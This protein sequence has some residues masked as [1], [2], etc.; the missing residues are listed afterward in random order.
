MKQ[1]AKLIH[2]IFLVGEVI[3]G[4]L[5]VMAIVFLLNFMTGIM[6]PQVVPTGWKIIRPPDEVSALI[7]DNDTVWTGG[8]NGLILINRNQSS[9]IPKPAGT[10]QF[11]FVHALLKDHTDA[12]W[13][14]HDGG[15]A[16]YRNG[17]WNTVSGAPFRRA[18]SLLED[19][20]GRI[21]VGSDAMVAYYDGKSW[22]T[23]SP[24]DGM[25]LASIDVLYEDHNGTIWM[26]CSAP[27]NAGLYKL[28]GTS[29]RYYSVEDGLPHQ[30]VRAIS[31]SRN[32]TIWIATGFS[33]NGGL[34]EVKDGNWT[35]STTHEGLA[36]N[37]TRS[38]YEDRSG[39]IWVGSEYDGMVVFDHGKRH[40]LTTKEG[41]AGNEVKVM[42]EDDNGVF[43]LGTSGGLTRIESSF[44]FANCSCPERI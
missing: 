29:W 31:Q 26:G 12:M 11:G 6:N 28:N 37:V 22:M 24:A 14:A 43:W 44:L 7:I 20:Q 5:F 33:N 25:R 16:C 34:V 18:L 41:L 1:Q 40:I 2:Y 42:A 30:T 35:V 3:V 8:K 10:P 27:S 36:G 39:R 21:W 19:R 9:Q 23:E 13:V 15:L 17:A 4:I 32:G 38:V